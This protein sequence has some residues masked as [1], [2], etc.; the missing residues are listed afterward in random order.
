MKEQVYVADIQ[1]RSRY[2]KISLEADRRC[3]F[4]LRKRVPKCWIL[5]I[6]LNEQI[7]VGQSI[8]INNLLNL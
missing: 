5:H 4:Q 7:D 3:I 6:L 2:I 1:K 8:Q